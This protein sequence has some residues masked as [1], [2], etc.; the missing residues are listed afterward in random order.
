MECDAFANGTG[1]LVTSEPGETLDDL[2]RDSVIRLYKESGALY[3]RGFGA[4]IAAFERFGNALSNDWMDNLGSGS[5]RETARGSS[6]GTIQNVAYV[7]G[8]SSQRLLSLPLH[9]D[10]AYVR[11]QPP[12]MMFLCGRPAR[13]GGETTLCDG[14]RLWEGLSDATRA[15][16][17]AKRLKYIR[18]YKPEE[19]ILLFRTSDEARLRAYCADNDLAFTLHSDGSCTTVF[20]K[21]AMA[22][23][24]YESRTA[25]VNSIPIQVWQEEALGRTAAL[26]RFE[27][28]S[29][30][31]PDVMEEIDDVAAG[32]TVNLPWQAGDFALVDNTRMMHGR[33][34]FTDVERTIY[35]RMCRSMDW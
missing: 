10:R 30:I 19:W 33:R 24:R 32:L 25:F 2:D 6:D 1:L 21:P 22:T 12:L 26:C 4:D 5:Y 11:S 34:A 15:L 35:A 31:P 28:G 8:L 7:Y 17:A 13:E 14:I 23:P 27:D 18:H 20:L 9:A 16:F 3:L 29:K